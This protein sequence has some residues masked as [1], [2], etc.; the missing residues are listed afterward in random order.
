MWK[1]DLPEIYRILESPYTKYQWKKLLYEQVN[2]YWKNYMIEMFFQLLYWIL[3]LCHLIHC[4]SQPV[5]W[6]IWEESV[7]YFPL[8]HHIVDIWYSSIQKYTNQVN[9]IHWSISKQYQQETQIEFQYNWRLCGQ[10]ILQAN[11]ARF[12][13]N[14]FLIF[15]VNLL[16]V[17]VNY[18]QR[19]M[20][21]CS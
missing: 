9:N 3:Y 2:S 6:Y 17:C 1:Y 5:K 11:R 19:T 18:G 7:P 8:P 13:Q 16:L 10:Y 14:L 12:N 20:Q 15:F 4:I 21:V